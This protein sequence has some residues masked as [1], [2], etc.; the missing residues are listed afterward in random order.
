MTSVKNSLFIY[1][2]GWRL[3]VVPPS[4]QSSTWLLS[5]T[6]D[7]VCGCEFR[8]IFHGNDGQGQKVIGLAEEGAGG[9]LLI[10]W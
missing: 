9:C 7:W 8:V 6:K 3:V 2:R 5:L 1:R 10:L 4:L